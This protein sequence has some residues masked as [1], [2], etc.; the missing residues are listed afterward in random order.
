MTSTAFS[1]ENFYKAISSCDKKYVEIK[2]GTHFA[3]LEQSAKDIFGE[4]IRFLNDYK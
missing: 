1:S 3:I 2:N 4:I